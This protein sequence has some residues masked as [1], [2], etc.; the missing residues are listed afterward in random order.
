MM[1]VFTGLAIWVL[2]GISFL[3]LWK[4]EE[5]P[6]DRP[7]ATIL[8]A[9]IA[10]LLSCVFLFRPHEDI[11]GGEDPG[12]YLNSSVTYL[13]QG[14]LFYT[15]PL[16][17]QIPAEGRSLFL[18][19]DAKFGKTKDACLWIRD[20]EKAKI[21]PWFLPAYP[22]MMS[23]VAVINPRLVLYVV[24]L[25]ALLTAIV[26][27]ILAVR[28]TGQIVGAPLVFALY[29]L[30]PLT[31]WHARCPRP[32]I[33]ASFFFFLGWALLVGAWQNRQRGA[34]L[35][36][37]LSAI[38][39]NL[40][41]FFHITAFFGTLPTLAVIIVLVV[42]GKKEFF[43]C[44]PVWLIGLLGFMCY[45]KYI[46]DPYFIGIHFEFFL[47]YP[48]WL[49]T[50]I[51]AGLLLARG[52]HLRLSRKPE[53]AT[54]SGTAVPRTFNL[55]FLLRIVLTLLVVGGI[56]LLF[57]QPA[58]G[59][60]DFLPRKGGFLK[61]TD[62]NCIAR[63]VSRLQAITALVGLAVLILRQDNATQS[64]LLLLVTLLPG[65]FF[66]GSMPN[67]MM[68]TRR[69]MLFV[70]P[71]IS[72]S[73][74]ALILLLTARSG[75]WRSIV[76]IGC[77][78][79]LIAAAFRGRSHLYTSV[80][81]AGFYRFLKPIA[82]NITERNGYLLAEYSRIAAP[83]EHFFG[84]RTLSLDNEQKSDYQI[85]ELIWRRYVMEKEPDR[86]VFFLT[87]Y[88]PPV[89]D[90]FDFIP[91][92]EATYFGSHLSGRQ[93]H[94]PPSRDYGL[95]LRLYEMRLT[96]GKREHSLFTNGQYCRKFDQ[97]NMGLRRFANIQT[98]SWS[99]SGHR[100]GKDQ[101]LELNIDQRINGE[102]VTEVLFFLHLKEEKA[103]ASWTGITVNFED[104]GKTDAK[105]H[106]LDNA[107]WLTRV[108]VPACN[109]KCRLTV[110]SDQPALLC[111]VK[112]RT[113]HTINEIEIPAERLEEEKMIPFHARW[114]R[115]KAQLL[116][117]M[118]RE[119]PA[120][121][122]LFLKGT[123]ISQGH[124]LT[125][126][127]ISG[128]SE[129]LE[130]MPDKWRWYVL[131]I[132]PEPEKRDRGWITFTTDKPCDPKL[133]NYPPDLAVLVGHVIVSPPRTCPEI[134]KD[135]TILKD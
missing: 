101:L 129:A 96:N 110:S 62:F 78:C 42:L 87:P 104:G 3:M 2:A 56:V 31:A 94:I 103:L 48:I 65:L 16:L 66:A 76:L 99:T 135:I 6:I 80:D 29:L 59:Q 111:Q 63:L 32:E 36:I 40:A 86:K 19:G 115:D 123:E 119:R 41:P 17:S 14:S 70:V 45:T 26:L 82:R 15:D 102:P 57:V 73:I 116:I 91:V 13:R 79:V 118:D 46:T 90:L 35:N 30:N 113:L 58:W 7:R 50:A 125:V 61:L 83:F 106:Y 55:L 64:R 22:I 133:G 68:D 67:Y 18:Y 108:C 60:L 23:T 54:P 105:C 25:F 127:G 9:V 107:W 92:H 128:D 53:F 38:C 11:F 121:L 34:F 97:G 49:I 71:L 117:T 4:K 95:M 52:I 72:L 8:L 114:A 74:S 131:P 126:Q 21:G 130:I 85:P 24:P 112:A 33:I 132:N 44:I 37:M 27:G 81:Y 12:S 28:L 51:I 134:K 47:S 120:D 39:L 75:R 1:I 43:I 109:A 89:S 20:M 98:R 10:I 77:T 88:Q 5:L 69:L 124:P 93:G 122:F 84:I 100:L